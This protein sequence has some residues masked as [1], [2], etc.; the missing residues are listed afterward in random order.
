MKRV[1]FEA[2]NLH[3]CRIFNLRSGN[4]YIAEF[5]LTLVLNQ[6]TRRAEKCYEA[7]PKKDYIFRRNMTYVKHVSVDIP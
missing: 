7:V 3:T 2:R 4:S 6:R 5:D 1:Y